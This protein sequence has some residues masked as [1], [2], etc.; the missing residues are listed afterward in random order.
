MRRF[1]VALTRG[2]PNGIPRPIELHAHDPARYCGDMLAWVH[3][4][5]ATETEFFRVLFDGDLAF[6]LLSATTGGDNDTEPTTGT[7]PRVS[8]VGTAFDGVARPLQVR[9]EQTLTAP[10]G[11]LAL[12]YQ[13]VLLLAFYDRTVAM[14]V[15]HAVVSHAL[16]HCRA[17]AN[18]AFRQQLGRLADAVA[19]SAQDYS[20][21]LS[22][23]HAAMDAAHRLTALLEVAQS[24][25]LPADEPESDLTPLFDSLLP[26]L[27]SMCD[28]SVQGLDTADALVFRV[29]NVSCVQAPLARFPVASEWHARIGRDLTRWLRDLSA[30]EAAS[31][32]DRAGVSHLLR[33]IQHFQVRAVE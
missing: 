9:I 32:L 3:Q 30:L 19:R 18:D 14:L 33:S 1:V 6:D 21:N 16:A 17:A 2:G 28:R 10:T 5:V 23:T 20:T 12:A 11:G 7:T 29:N 26:A 24:S 31:V 22:A 8:M 27:D 15:P 25:L 13:L 4:A